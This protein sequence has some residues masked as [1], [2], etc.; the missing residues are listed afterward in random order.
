MNLSISTHGSG[1]RHALPNS[2]GREVRRFNFIITFGLARVSVIAVHFG[3][4]AHGN[5]TL[6][7]FGRFL[8]YYDNHFRLW[9]KGATRKP[10]VA[11]NTVSN[12]NER[13]AVCIATKGMGTSHFG[14][15]VS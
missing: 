3:L 12:H 9:I 5:S 8:E 1:G 10:H 13:Y 6:Y 14:P 11:H 2:D 7:I 15:A 4:T